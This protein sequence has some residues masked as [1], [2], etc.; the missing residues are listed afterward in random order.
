MS[1]TQ[2]VTCQACLSPV[3]QLF[4]RI[5]LLQPLLCQNSRL[6][7]PA[8]AHW[9][10]AFLLTGDASMQYVKI[11]STIIG[12][13]CVFPRKP[14]NTLCSFL[15]RAFCAHSFFYVCILMYFAILGIEPRTSNARQA[16]YTYPFLH[17]WQT[18]TW[19]VL[20]FSVCVCVCGVCV[21]VCVWFPMSGVFLILFCGWF[22]I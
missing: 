5:P 9:P 18:L 12:F 14:S 22:I 13:R 1:A 20:T 21:C 4:P 11:L 17:A 6:L 8:S 19:V 3:A 7:F 2:L 16:L 10:Q 15:S